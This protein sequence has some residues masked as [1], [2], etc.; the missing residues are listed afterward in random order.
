LKRFCRRGCAMCCNAKR[1][2]RQIGCS[3]LLSLLTLS[4]SS[5]ENGCP[6]QTAHDVIACVLAR[7]PDVLRAQSEV[8]V[9]AFLPGAAGQRPNPELDSQ[10]T[11]FGKA[12]V[13]PALTTEANLVHT[14]E[15]G[16]KRHHRLKRAE[17][18]QSAAQ[19]RLRRTREQLAVEGVLKL[20][21]LRQIIS[22]RRAIE[23]SMT[24][25]SDIVRSLQSRPRRSGDQDVSLQVFLLAKT[26]YEFQVA[27]LEQEEN[28]LTLWFTLATG[29]AKPAILAA[30]PQESLQWP[31]VSTGPVTANGV[32]Q[33][34]AART[35]ESKANLAMAESQAWPDLKAGPR[36]E[37]ESGNG[38]STLGGGAALSLPLPLYQRNQGERRVASAEA[39]QATLNL[40]LT[41]RELDTERQ[42]WL[43]AYHSFVEAWRRSPGPDEMEKRHRTFEIEF[44]RG[45]IPASLTVEAHRQMVEFTKARHEI[46]LRAIEALWSLYALDG[47]VETAPL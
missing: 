1:L 20:H 4:A 6:A 41:K 34:A 40:Q 38:E 37:V 2:L 36:V 11:A 30:L 28:A 43:A 17:A 16:D 22:E 12:E 45:L 25:F 44:H 19:A 8:W 27:S 26:D 9:A 13:Q 39:E 32:L 23:E 21:R 46:E 33:I 5:A 10:V 29:L 47:S 15:L 18:R 24:S 14:F 7:H 35:A 3:A 42:R 31:E